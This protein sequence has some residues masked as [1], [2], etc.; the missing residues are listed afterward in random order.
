MTGCD[1][2]SKLEGELSHQFKNVPDIQ[3][4]DKAINTMRTLSWMT[5]EACK[6]KAQNE[7]HRYEEWEN[8]N[9][10]V[11]KQFELKFHLR[12]ATETRNAA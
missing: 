7:D 3:S 10:S 5:P 12:D 1:P 8:E 11:L 2:D 9:L 6:K 4:V